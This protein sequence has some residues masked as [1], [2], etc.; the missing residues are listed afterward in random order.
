[1]SSYDPKTYWIEQG[2]VYRDRFQYNKNY[3]LQE[4]M[5]IDYLK[6]IN[7]F[8]SVLEVGCGFGRITKLLL[9]N[10]P[11][12]RKYVAT[13]MS[14]DQIE[15]AKD[16]LKNVR[17]DMSLVFL[18]SDIQSLKMDQDYD[19][20]IASEVLMHVLPEEIVSVIEKLVKLSHR[21]II[22]IDYYEHPSRKLA[23]HNFLHRYEEIYRGIS[24]VHD[25]RRIPI[26][27]NGIFKIDTKQ[28]IFHARMAL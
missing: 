15:K 6:S 16:Y 23:T 8:A 27:K 11:N 9:L 4:R 7:P 17:K 5:L 20:V 14:E 25:V 2:K 10:F 1:M 24:S 13:D 26:I 18:L 21:D 22:N 19:L 12:I 28:S 3:D